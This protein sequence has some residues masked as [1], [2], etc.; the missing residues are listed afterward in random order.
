MTT[1]KVEQDVD[2]K[3]IIVQALRTSSGGSRDV[4]DITELLCLKH[5]NLLRYSKFDLYHSLEQLI[6]D[7]LHLDN[8]FYHLK[9]RIFRRSWGRSTVKFYLLGLPYKSESLESVSVPISPEEAT[10][11]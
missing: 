1:L 11:E 3:Q 2:L 10:S 5:G 6:H 4:R 7:G 8:M 9:V